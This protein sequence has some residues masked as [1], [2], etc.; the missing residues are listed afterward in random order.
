MHSFA[1]WQNI[2]RMKNHT[3]NREPSKELKEQG[4]AVVN[5]I[6]NHIGDAKLEKTINW[7]SPEEE[8]QF[9]ENDFA[10]GQKA[11]LLNL[12]KDII[13]HTVNLHSPKYMGHQVAVTHP[14][15]V[16]S[17]ALI[18]GLNQGMAVYE[19]GMAGNAI[20]KVLIRHLAQKFGFGK[21]AAGVFTSGGSLANLTA[22]L[23]AR[24][25]FDESEF[26]NLV[27]LVSG[28]AHYSIARAAT[29]M[30]LSAKNIIRIPVNE[31]FQMDTSL[32]EDYYQRAVNDGKKILAVVACSCS[33][34]LGAYDDLN[35]IGDWA[36]MKKVWFH[37]DGAHGA[38]VVYS[39]KY[40]NLIG[41]IEKADSVIMDYHKLLM[42]P[43]LTTAV[44]YK[45]GSDAKR[46]FAQKAD[47]LFTDITND[48]WYNGGKRTVECTRPMSILNVYTMLRVY[49][50][51]IFRDN[52]DTLYSLSKD[53]AAMVS[54]NENFELA[55]EPESNIVCFRFKTDEDKD[56][57]N[58]KI[59]DALLCDGEFYIVNTVI[60]GSFWFRVTIQNPRTTKADF[61]RLLD[62]ISKIKGDVETANLVADN[63]V[64]SR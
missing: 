50:E 7:K 60:N 9:W 27:I 8:L 49:G 44:I 53:F 46:T 64:V 18:A 55:L 26:N 28:E 4:Q 1:W 17:N 5:L 43:S 16:L 61:K 57:L 20:E 29:I 62:Y 42:T 54:E 2:K 39:P 10:S 12:F 59:A 3:Y 21:D 6:M 11:E 13:D 47:Y 31:K 36:A 15:T 35:T 34:A 37:V 32:L 41:G 51:E 58:R 40:K 25:Y 30:G 63:G 33:T 23:T 45:R 48:D 22:L 56:T 19:M 24:S 38:A 52:I 14:V